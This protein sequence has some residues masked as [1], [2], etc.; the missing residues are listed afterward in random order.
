MTSSSIK[1]TDEYILPFL[2]EKNFSSVEKYFEIECKSYDV[3]WL[4][5]INGVEL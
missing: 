1:R 4:D 2:T 3:R 5:R